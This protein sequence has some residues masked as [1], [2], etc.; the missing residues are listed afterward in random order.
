MFALHV[1]QRYSS[2]SIKREVKKIALESPPANML[3]QPSK[4]SKRP[5]TIRPTSV[6]GMSSF[7]VTPAPPLLLSRSA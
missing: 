3:K 7:E 6:S 4:T 5:V 2:V 1:Q